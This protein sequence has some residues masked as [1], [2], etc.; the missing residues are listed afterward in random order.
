MT[1][2]DYPRLD[3]LTDP[4][5][6][7]I[8]GRPLINVLKMWAHSEPLLPLIAQLGATQFAA[9]ELS[10]RHRELVVLV[11][12]HALDAPYVWNQHVAISEA[13]GVTGRERDAIRLGAH[14]RLSDAPFAPAD[15]AILDFALAVST[16]PRVSDSVFVA[17]RQQLSDRAVVEAVSVAGY[18]FTI[19]KMTTTLEVE[20]D[21]FADATVLDAG[22]D[23][24][25]DS[26]VRGE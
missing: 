11:V 26:G 23:L 12:A 7:L 2:I 20:S 10:P 24:A 16:G 8:A 4:T 3:R 15:T 19:A 9:L 22:I 13:C 1:R 14:W 6:A 21:E 18:Y 25:R 17:A 5:K